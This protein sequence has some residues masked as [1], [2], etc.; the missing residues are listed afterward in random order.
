MKLLIAIPALNEEEAIGTIIDRTLEASRFIVSHSPVTEVQI[1]VVSDGSTDRTVEIAKTYGNGI[2]LIVFEHN[3]GYGA[4]IKEAW[5]DSEA[6]LL[7]FLDADGTCD[8]RFFADL[9]RELEIQRADIALGCRL[10]KNTQ[11]PAIRQ[12]GNHIFASILTLSSGVRV[13]DTASGMRVL[14]RDT[15]RKLLP[16]PNGLHFTPA[17][18]AR[19]VLGPRGDTKLI[20]LD[21]PYHERE[22]VSKLHVVRDGLRFLRI[23][24]EAL[25]LYR[26]FRPLFCVGMVSLVLA[27]VTMAS[28]VMYYLT[29]RSVQEWMIYRF[30]IGH[31]AATNAF[32]M[33]SIAILTRLIVRIAVTGQYGPPSF[34]PVENAFLS[35]FFWLYPGL[36]VVCGT[37]LVV[38]IRFGSHAGALTNEHWS[39]FIAMSFFY[40]VAA[41]LVSARLAAY[42]LKLVAEQ[43][44]YS[45]SERVLGTVVS[46]T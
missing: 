22:G 21:M 38:P 23:I 4:A 36:L 3:R 1:T 43:V 42:F 15:Y 6:D 45:R 31:L 37:I 10:S 12:A 41:I 29:H 20:E 33:F 9:C 35:P 27:V 46:G 44:A 40:L 16:L 5:K 13:R 19:A 8:P 34:T 28:P 11:M 17:M 25:F 30:I 2:R 24:L 32:L 39:R 18:S 14:R 26:P 7:G